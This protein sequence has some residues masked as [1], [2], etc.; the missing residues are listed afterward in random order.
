MSPG[1]GLFVYLN[2]TPIW[3]MERWRRF[4]STAPIPFLKRNAI[5][6]RDVELERLKLSIEKNYVTPAGS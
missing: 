2:V 6:K 3:S 4:M 5:A 1:L